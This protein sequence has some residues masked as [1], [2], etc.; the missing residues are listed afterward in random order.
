MALTTTA[1]NAAKPTAKVR[2]LSDGG[3]LQL[4]IMPNGSK[5]WRYAY[6]FDGRQKLLALG[7][8]TNATVPNRPVI[9]LA[10]A[11]EL[12]DDARRKLA[13]GID[14]GQ[15]KAIEQA[16]KTA[17]EKAAAAA[18]ANTFCVIAGE[19]IAKLEREGK[20]DVTISKR[21]WLLEK[22]F[23]KLGDKA[24]RDISAADVLAVLREVENDGRYET[25]IRL[26]STI[27]AVFRYAIA[28]AR[29]ENDPTFPLR[30]ALTTPT[31]KHQSAIVEPKRIGALM[32]AIDGYNR[33]A[34]RVAL[35]LLALTAVRPGELRAARWEEFDLEGAFWT[36][37]AQRMKMRKTHKLPLAPRSVDLLR[38]LQEQSGAAGLL[39]PS[40]KR[41]DVAISE[42]TLNQAL[43]RLGFGG[44]MVSHGFRAMFSSQ[45]NEHSPFSADA[46][47]LSLGHAIGG[48]AVRRAYGRHELLDERRALACWWADRLDMLRRSK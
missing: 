3:G 1:I 25:A 36:I 17:E 6:R 42:N 40:L 38:G 30:G 14:P 34:T 19:L 7:P 13:F 45:A 9:G 27:G 29:A 39:F 5:L 4:W 47:E 28:S 18:Q 41:P 20:A 11:R 2:K 15:Q 48:G 24:I 26:R 23:P 35:Q 44:E 32:R 31:V 43:V 12:R 46:I 10:A 33:T 21:R 8:Y 16:E 22:A 37:P